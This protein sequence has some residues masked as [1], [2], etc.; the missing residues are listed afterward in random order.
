M[1][2]KLTR[3]E[4]N[5]LL[6][7][8]PTGEHQRAIARAQESLDAIYAQFVKEHISGEE[9][10]KSILFKS[11][12]LI[13]DQMNDEPHDFIRDWKSLQGYLYMAANSEPCTCCGES[14]LDEM[15]E[16]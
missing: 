12:R 13:E 8:L 6:D 3:E 11:Y 9:N 16:D 5:K 10:Y 4:L 2:T 14:F 7:A 1:K 15:Y